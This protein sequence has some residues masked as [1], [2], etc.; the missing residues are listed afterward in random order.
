MRTS[1]ALLLVACG[2]SVSEPAGPSPEPTSS[3]DTAPV[4]DADS[5]APRH[6][7]DTGPPPVA[8]DCATIP[9]QPLSVGRIPGAK[10]Y[11]DLA[12][13]PTGWAIGN[14]NGNASLLMATYDGTT[15]VFVPNTGTIQQMAWLPDGDLA[16]AS[17]NR[18]ILRV[19]PN[20]ATTIIHGDIRP[21]GLI[22][23]P[24]GLLWAADQDKVHKVDPVTGVAQVVVPSGILPSGSPRVINFDLSDRRL[25]IGTL[26]GSSGRIYAVDLDEDLQPVAPPFVFAT[27]VGTGGYH[28]AIG[29][30]VCGYLYVP[31]YNTSALYRVSPSGQVQTIHDAGG[32][33]NADYGHGV[34]WGNGVGGWREDAIYL[35]LP[36]DA[37]NVQEI[38]IGVPPK[39]WTGGV[40]VNLPD[41]A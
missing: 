1:I 36:Y 41:G 24:D 6:T 9:V 2:G 22:L 3:L 25:Y 4:A 5:A 7:G 39:G 26:G 19:A 29:V 27:G 15:Q 35:P 34:E 17:D 13:T 32:L 18:G 30:D 31:D 20:G 37:N 10:G 28:D 23:G 33:L 8:F 21:Y 38:V 11:H 40:A 14:A 12:F 16:I